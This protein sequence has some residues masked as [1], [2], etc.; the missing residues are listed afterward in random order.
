MEPIA[1]IASR[2]DYADAGHLSHGALLY[3]GSLSNTWGR[4][5]IGLRTSSPAVPPRAT[6]TPDP[7]VS[8]RVTV[9]TTSTGYRLRLV[10]VSHAEQDDMGYQN[11]KHM[12]WFD[13][14][15]YISICKKLT[16]N[17]AIH[18]W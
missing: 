13:E 9:R 6:T 14:K 7:L 11:M 8:V 17:A 15:Y 1:G 12:M 18:F 2:P 10:I 4:P 3:A 16:R 5:L